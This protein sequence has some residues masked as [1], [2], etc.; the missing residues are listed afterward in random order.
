MECGRGGSGLGVRK[1][2]GHQI[3]IIVNVAIYDKPGGAGVCQGAGAAWQVETK[4]LAVSRCRIGQ[5]QL[6]SLWFG[7]GRCVVGSTSLP[8][9]P[10]YGLIANF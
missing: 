5:G 2:Y 10:C 8:T 1:T 6:G 7:R 3:I 9:A 4:L